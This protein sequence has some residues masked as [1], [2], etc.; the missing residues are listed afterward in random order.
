[1]I[2][3]AGRSTWCPLNEADFKPCQASYHIDGFSSADIIRLRCA[4]STLKPGS[5]VIL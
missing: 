3:V 1:M 4:F 2:S 5:I